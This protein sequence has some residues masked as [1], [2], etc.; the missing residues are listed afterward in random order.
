[1]PV[2]PYDTHTTV[3]G[4]GQPPPPFLGEGDQFLGDEW[5]MEVVPRLP[6]NIEQQAR[7]LGALQRKRGLRNATDLLRALL[8]YALCTPSF[9]Q[10]GA[11]AVL[12]E[13]ADLSEAAWRKRLRCA[14]LWLGWLV[15]ELLAPPPPT[16]STGIV[17]HARHARRI[18][19][20][21]VKDTN[22]QTHTARL[23]A[24]L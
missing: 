6:A 2:L 11:W 12:V 8:S 7:A 24:A 22:G 19:L 10:L 3:T 20:V 15:G 17:D 9:R 21:D 1:M 23:E 4:Q 13:L 16:G 5:A 14:H 18:L